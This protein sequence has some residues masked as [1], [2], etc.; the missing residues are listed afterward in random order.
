MPP[1]VPSCNVLVRIY[2]QTTGISPR[3]TVIFM[4]VVCSEFR[5]IGRL[6]SRRERLCTDPTAGV[7]QATT[8]DTEIISAATTNEITGQPTD[9][10]DV[11]DMGMGDM[12]CLQNSEMD[13]PRT[14]GWYSFP[15]QATTQ[16][17]TDSVEWEPAGPSMSGSG[18]RSDWLE[19]RVGAS[20]IEYMD[21]PNEL[22]FVEIN[23]QTDTSPTDMF[24]SGVSTPTASDL[25]ECL[26]AP[27]PTE[28]V[29]CLSAPTPS[30]LGE[31]LSAPTPSELG[32]CSPVPVGETESVCT[33]DVPEL[34]CDELSS[35]SSLSGPGFVSAED[36]ISRIL[37]DEETS[38]VTSSDD[39]STTGDSWDITTSSDS[40]PTHLV[41]T[42]LCREVSYT[43]TWRAYR[44]LMQSTYT[45]R[46]FMFN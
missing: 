29:E 38:S 10:A 35:S 21:G 3:H 40:E 46:I 28:L 8:T 23:S 1:Y 20:G 7:R 26:S 25:G 2:K 19:D 14:T 4:C 11:L 43:T 36:F 30:E 41:I 44:S 24:S 16:L 17:N 18:A 42:S 5:Q 15:K 6:L 9:V 13:T 33:F 27:T 34:E 22:V 12:V 37:R 45:I 32:E 31:C 39:R